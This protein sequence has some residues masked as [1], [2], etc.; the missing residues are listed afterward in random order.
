MTGLLA[1]FIASMV[2]WAVLF[3]VAGAARGLIAIEIERKARNR[4]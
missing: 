4:E 2:L 3:A 1:F